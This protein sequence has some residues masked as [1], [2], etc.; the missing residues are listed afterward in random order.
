MSDLTLI[1]RRTIR[2]TPERLFAAWTEPAQLQRWWGPAQVE[3]PVAEIDLRVGGRYRLANRFP[4]GSV[5][6]IAGTFEAITPPRLLIYSWELSAGAIAPGGAPPPAQAVER[7]TVRFE[8]KGDA[9]EIVVTHERIADEAAR[10]SHEQG[11]L[12]CLDG[13]AELFP[14]KSGAA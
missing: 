14:A 5:W 6:W 9:T 11:W 4:D 3:C 12:G 1:V 8:R 13:L 10:V 7:V 2:A